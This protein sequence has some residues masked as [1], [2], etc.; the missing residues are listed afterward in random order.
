MIF[1]KKLVGW[2]LFFAA[3]T[4]VGVM[5]LIPRCSSPKDEASACTAASCDVL[6]I[7]VRKGAYP[8]TAKNF[9]AAACCLSLVAAQCKPTPSPPP[10]NPPPS[11]TASGGATG[12]GGAPATGGKASTGGASATGGSTAAPMPGCLSEAQHAASKAMAAEPRKFNKPTVPRTG[13]KAMQS[14]TVTGASVFHLPNACTPPDYAGTCNPLDQDGVGSCTGDDAA[15]VWSTAPYPG[16]ATQTDALS[17]YSKA[18]WY[19]NGCAFDA[20]ACPNAYPP[21]DTGSYASSAFKAATW[22]GW[23][24][25]TR[26]VVQTLQGWHDALLEG[27]CGFDQNWYANGLQTDQCGHVA[28]TGTLLGGHSTAALGYDAATGDWLFFNSWGRDFGVGGI[29]RHTSANMLKL[30]Q[31]GANLVCPNLPAKK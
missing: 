8:M 1:T 17:C 19:D 7:A 26:A 23:F 5:S 2:S 29:Y 9:A 13:I 14:A 27:P 28:I 10:P 24:T 16:H 6:T 20:K 21:N 31:S 4:F 15:Q 30:W 3:Y 12:A 25:G 18:T 11:P 22:L